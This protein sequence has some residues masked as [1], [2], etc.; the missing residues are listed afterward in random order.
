M[1]NYCIN[2]LLNLK[3]VKVKNIIHADSYVKIF[4]QTD[5][6]EHKCPDCG[7][8]TK[9]IHDYRTQTIKDLPF[10]E[11]DCYLVL[12]KRRYRCSCGKRFF[13]VCFRANQCLF[14]HIFKDSGYY[15]LFLSP[16]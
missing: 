9:R 2:K 10:Q 5:A 7:S 4:I 11:K 14:Q 1:H 12:K 13:E 6:R 16:L 8:L 15:Q 3:E